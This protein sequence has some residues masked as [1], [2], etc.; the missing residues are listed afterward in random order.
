M[1]RE[2]LSGKIVSTL[3]PR[4][5][6]SS[7]CAASCMP[8]SSG[9]RDLP[10]NGDSTFRLQVQRNLF[11]LD[12]VRGNQRHHA[13]IKDHDLNFVAVHAMDPTLNQIQ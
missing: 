4:T 12:M 1:S 6:S 9:C 13:R 8:Q 11:H 2:L 5:R 3:L 10:S 7:T